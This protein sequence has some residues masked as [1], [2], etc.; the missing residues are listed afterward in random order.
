MVLKIV[1]F[2]C[3]RS[4][5]LSVPIHCDAPQEKRNLQTFCRSKLLSPPPRRSDL[6]SGVFFQWWGSLGNYAHQDKASRSDF[7][8]FT[9]QVAV[10]ENAETVDYLSESISTRKL[11]V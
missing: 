5:L 7:P 1:V 2:C 8:H 10:V 11:G 6:L 4:I 3:R 9:I